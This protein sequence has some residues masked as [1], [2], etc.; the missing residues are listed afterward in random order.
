VIVITDG[1]YCSVCQ[2]YYKNRQLPKGSDGTFI[3]KPFS[4]WN[5][6]TGSN[7][8]DNK[9]LKHDQSL[10]HKTAMDVKSGGEVMVKKSR[11]V[12]SM[13][14]AQSKA[15]QEENLKFV[16]DIIDATYF[17]LLNEIPHTTKFEPLCDLLVRVD[18]SG[19]LKNFIES[20]PDN[21]TYRS[22]TTV[23]EFVECTA[24]WVRDTVAENIRQSPIIAIMADE[25]TDLRLRADLAVCFRYLLNGEPQEAF[26]KIVN[27]TSTDAETITTTIL[28]ILSEHRIELNKIYWQAFD[29]GANFAG[30]RNGVQAKL[31]VACPNAQYI[32]CRSHAL[33]LAAAHVADGFK[34]LKALFSAFN[35][36]WRVVHKSPK[37]HRKFTEVQMILDD[38]Q[39]ELVRA[40]DTRWTSNYR[41]VVAVKRCLKSI[42]VTLQELH[43]DAADLSSEAGG[44]LLT[45]Q[46]RKSSILIF[47][48]SEILA[49]MNVLTLTI[50]S[51]KLSLPDLPAKLEAAVSRLHEIEQ[52]PSTYMNQFATYVQSCS[53]S[54]P[55][56]GDEA[57]CNNVHASIVVP[58]ITAL[59][60]NM[61]RRLGD[62]MKSLSIAANI[63]D[64]SN[65]SDFSRDEL[66]DQLSS[67]CDAFKLPQEVAKAEWA[68]F[69][70]YLV[71]MQQSSNPTASCSASTSSSQCETMVA[72]TTA[73]LKK[74]ITSDLADA[75]P[76]LSKLATIMLTCPIGTASVERSFS[77]MN[78]LCTKLRQRL[79]SEHLDDLMIIA[80][81]GPT[82]LSDD[83][84]KCLAYCWYRSKPRR[85]QL[86][87]S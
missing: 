44:L 33:N 72:P 24:K 84:K 21:A 15:Q 36:L 47:A 55:L 78:R 77:T 27:L 74:L 82:E 40:G 6:S 8:K 64:P 17:L 69:L 4:N 61:E 12:F 35:S 10:S 81:E 71:R 85:M 37:C 9:L 43:V 22:T 34:P 58:Y 87:Q 45:F 62:S 31:R 41:A 7:P 65:K 60:K 68:C 42:V 50:Q 52:D 49:P 32:H 76:T 28:G 79:T 29:G 63:F 75:F 57:E 80:S 86:P 1:A 53:T 19:K 51:T 5:K 54:Y 59:L 3:I 73:V 16:I 39:L 14:Y 67:L 46:N 70:P 2:E 13:L 30:K 20:S 26:L 25:A 56:I 66:A 38:P 48:L 11:T 18:H 83:D 23:T